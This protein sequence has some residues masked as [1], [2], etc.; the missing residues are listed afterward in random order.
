MKDRRRPARPIILVGAN[1]DRTG[2]DLCRHELAQMF[3]KGDVERVLAGHI[4]VARE[5]LTWV[6][7]SST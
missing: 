1:T 5:N 4:G 7:T 2:G 3:G 6:Q